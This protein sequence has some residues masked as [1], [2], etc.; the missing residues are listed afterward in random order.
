MYVY[1]QHIERENLIICGL[2]MM[3]SIYHVFLC[4]EQV[5]AIVCCEV[6]IHEVPFKI[7]E[8]FFVN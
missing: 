3:G 1:T 2:Q 5:F 6:C 8:L 4:H 7:L